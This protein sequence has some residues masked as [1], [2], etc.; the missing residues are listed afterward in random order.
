LYD[1]VMCIVYLSLVKNWWC[2]CWKWLQLY[3]VQCSSSVHEFI[4]GIE[5]TLNFKHSKQSL[6]CFFQMRKGLKEFR[7]SL[8]SQSNVRWKR[9][10]SLPQPF[11]CYPVDRRT[12][13]FLVLYADRFVNPC[14]EF[15]DVKALKDL[16]FCW[17]I[18][19]YNFNI[20][21]T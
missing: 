17:C 12:H 11:K 15:A 6:N 8:G 3:I 1:C 21:C 2:Y 5:T 7:I 14:L 9:F 16:E 20:A 18:N 4:A 19:L 13:Y 10:K